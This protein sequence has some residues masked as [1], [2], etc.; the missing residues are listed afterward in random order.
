[1]K[2]SCKLTFEYQQK[3]QAKQVMQATHVDDDSYVKAQVTGKTLKATIESDSIPS[4]LHTLDDY[5][6]CVS[7]AEKIVNKN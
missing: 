5:L 1:M 3:Q 7:I 6:S 2:I 4:M